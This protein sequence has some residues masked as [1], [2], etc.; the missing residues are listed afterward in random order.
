MFLYKLLLTLNATS[1]MAIIY[2]IK[3]GWTIGKVPNHLFG[4]LLLIIPI[5]LSWI[6]LIMT[7]FLGTESLV[8]NCQ[9][10]SLADGE[11]LPIY[12]GYFFV[13]VGVSDLFTMAVVYLIVFVF[14]FLSQTQYYNPI[15]LLFGY[16]YYHV[17][18]ENGTSIFIIRKG[19]VIRNSA[20]LRFDHL[21][22]LNNTTFIE[23][24]TK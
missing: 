5:F 9:E 18:T 6:S 20:E 14:T 15:Y 13:S 24:K 4:I 16:H 22:R 7:R 10:F 3:E 2:V 12:L 19:P 1:W 11:F 8:G 17:T 23:R 21:H